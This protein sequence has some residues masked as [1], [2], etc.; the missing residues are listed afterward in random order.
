VKYELIGELLVEAKGKLTG[1][2]VLADGKMEASSAGPGTILGKEATS[3]DT[4]VLTPMPN[5]V[6]MVEGNGMIM[7]TEGEF[8]MAKINGIAWFTGKALKS[9]GRGACYFMTT[10]PK[11]ASL[12]K[13]V[14][15]WE[16]ES[17]ENG[18]WSLKV[19]AWK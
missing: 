16:R 14:G 19:W 4:G 10:A 12:N 18:D 9:T 17:D 7:T 15:V 2:R 5:G 3:M 11:L 1:S 8:V 6:L 13:I